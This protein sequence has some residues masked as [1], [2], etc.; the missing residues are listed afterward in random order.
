VIS[1]PGGLTAD[2]GCRTTTAVSECAAL[3]AIVKSVRMLKLRAV[4]VRTVHPYDFWGLVLIQ[5][6]LVLAYE[7]GVEKRFEERRLESVLRT[8]ATRSRELVD[9][10]HRAVEHF[11][12]A[13]VAVEVLLHITGH[14]QSRES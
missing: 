14:L 11:N 9:V 12:C 10:G 1:R 6:Q 4:D 3:I 2:A 7:I 8:E 13:I 5:S